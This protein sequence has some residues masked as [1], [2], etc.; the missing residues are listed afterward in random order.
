MLYV[1]Y[2][3]IKKERFIYMDSLCVGAVWMTG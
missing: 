2:T 3:S 1:N